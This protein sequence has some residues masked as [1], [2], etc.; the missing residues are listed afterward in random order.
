MPPRQPIP[1]TGAARSDLFAL[2]ESAPGDSVRL[3]RVTEMVEIDMDSLTYL[4]DHNF[5]PGADA[6]VRS[7]APDGTITLELDEGTIALGPALAAQLFVAAAT[8]S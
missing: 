2:S 7:K 5:T 6:T 3:E 4:S 8:A 1:G